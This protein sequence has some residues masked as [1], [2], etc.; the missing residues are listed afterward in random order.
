MKDL[1]QLLYVSTAVDLIAHHDLYQILESSR[2]NNARMDIT[3]VLCSSGSHFIQL[4]EGPEN[5]IV[6]LYAKILD[7]CRH[8][9]CVLIG[10][11]PVAARSFAK[12]AMGYI[13]QQDGEI[14][15][16]REELM[17]ARILRTEEG[18]LIHA[19]QKFLRRLKRE[20]EPQ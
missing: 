8:R 7:D 19:M 6:R 1:S 13:P 17:R 20:R 14:R 9:D 16:D 3:G 10:I 18:E 15:L 2:E 5:S 11:A 12:W 4:L